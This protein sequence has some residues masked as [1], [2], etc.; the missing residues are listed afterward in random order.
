M[1]SDGVLPLDTLIYRESDT[2]GVANSIDSIIVFLNPDTTNL[3]FN[4]SANINIGGVNSNKVGGLII[5]ETSVRIEVVNSFINNDEIM[6]SGL[7]LLASNSIPKTNLFLDATGGIGVTDFVTIHSLRVGNPSIRSSNDQVFIAGH[8]NAEFLDN[9]TISEDGE[10][11]S[12]TIRDG[13]KV[14]LPED[15]EI[16]WNDNTLSFIEF[17]NNVT[18]DKININGI[19]IISEKLLY[20]PVL[21]NFDQN[22]E[23]IINSGLMVDVN[24]TNI[25]EEDNHRLM[26]EVN[27]QN[28]G[29]EYI[30]DFPIVITRPNIMF[31][32]ITGMIVNQAFEIS[33]IHIKEHSDYNTIKGET[34]INII[35]PDSLQNRVEFDGNS[36]L[37]FTPNDLLSP[38]Y[39]I[40][41]NTITLTPEMNFDPNTVLLI[42]GIKLIAKED[43]I[44]NGNLEFT[45]RDGMVGLPFDPSEIL[46]DDGGFYISKPELSS[47]IIQR[48]YIQN[49]ISQSKPI[50]IKDDANN[51]AF[52][53]LID[54][55]R[56]K[57]PEDA[58]WNVNDDLISVNGVS[59]IINSIVSFSSDSQTV[60]IKIQNSFDDEYLNLPITIS[61]LSIIPTSV[62]ETIGNLEFKLINNEVTNIVDSKDYFVGDIYFSSEKQNV[63]MKGGDEVSTLERITIKE[64]SPVVGDNPNLR[65]NKLSIN[66]PHNL[67][68]I[69]NDELQ[70]LNINSEQ[71]ENTIDNVINQGDVLGRD[72]NDF[73]K[74][75]INLIN[76]DYGSTLIIDS[77]LITNNSHSQMQSKSNKLKLNLDNEDMLLSDN[78]MIFLA[79]INVESNSDNLLI[80]NE[81]TDHSIKLN[82]IEISNDSLM[83]SISNGELMILER[84]DFFTINIPNYNLG[85]EISENPPI[86]YGSDGQI[87]EDILFDGLINDGKTL[88][89]KIDNDIEDNLYTI[90]NLF[91]NVDNNSKGKYNIHFSENNKK[92]GIDKKE[93][94][95]DDPKIS[96]SGNKTIY[97]NSLLTH[98]L[99]DITITES[100]YGLLNRAIN[101]NLLK[102]KLGGENEN[103]HLI[104]FHKESQFDLEDNG[105]NL[106]LSNLNFS[107][108]ES[109]ELSD[110]L[111]ELIDSVIFDNNLNLSSLINQSVKLIIDDDSTQTNFV[112]TAEEITLIPSNFFTYP[113]VFQD[114]QNQNHINY[115]IKESLV[116]GGIYT[117]YPSTLEFDISVNSDKIDNI[118]LDVNY[119]EISDTTYLEGL[120]VYSQYN[121]F[122]SLYF[123]DLIKIDLIIPDSIV[124]NI[125]SLLDANRDSSNINMLFTLIE[126]RNING[127][128]SK[129][130]FYPFTTPVNFDFIDIYR[131]INPD[132]TSILIASNA[133]VDPNKIFLNMTDLSTNNIENIDDGNISVINDT[134]EIDLQNMFNDKI[135]GL[136]YIDIFSEGVNTNLIN[137]IQFGR[138]YYIDRSAPMI[139]TIIPEPGMKPTGEGLDI[140]FFD[141]IEINFTEGPL[142]FNENVFDVSTGDLLYSDELIS[143]I[144][145]NNCS[146]DNL[147]FINNE[148][149]YEETD[150]EI[151]ID[152][153]NFQRSTFL[154]DFQNNSSIEN[155]ELIFIVEIVDGAGNNQIDTLRYVLIDESSNS[156]LMNYPNPFSSKSSETTQFRY[157][158]PSESN[159]GSLIIYNV[160]GHVVYIKKLNSNELSAGTHTINWGGNTNYGKPLASGVYFSIIKFSNYVTRVNKV[161]II[162]E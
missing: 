29:A 95:I 87:T 98:I 97:V 6:I 124:S 64:Q 71:F 102:L 133:E 117:N 3:T 77:L 53:N 82:S 27:H 145:T 19:E 141:E 126:N 136:Y 41:L 112:E 114:N 4:T 146:V 92:T 67:S 142:F 103:S 10:V 62:S 111:I 43:K 39:N 93:I 130:T 9:V 73:K 48:H 12:I 107:V 108:G 33:T 11:G 85:W 75:I 148:F 156:F 96:M 162:N 66:I 116:G 15:I 139:N 45:I 100:D 147:L 13:I 101:N 119:E 89:F 151:L 46:G 59:G 55:I 1:L 83:Y 144:F 2:T 135:D 51:P 18:K 109:I 160:A 110:I 8:Q 23:L 80:I 134:I 94:I 61:G 122:D 153:N 25:V 84:D 65:L 60:M 40:S 91:L 132:S 158:L 24:E 52:G 70:D 56:I 69:W 20:I 32:E 161:A 99:P 113:V 140:T 78:E 154:T 68:L 106:I 149:V 125:N 37:S 118:L 30:D 127:D 72:P 16:I 157:S 5:N 159:N 57:I 14:H 81:E 105:K 128:N 17:E 63:V 131:Q 7:E 22:D 28:S 79:S 76:F 50:I 137:S 155:G 121:D 129:I 38:N 36:E 35:I 152:S 47:E 123:T 49:S 88:S 54:T 138:L 34:D 31:E 150:L 74:F 115:Y 42:D 58:L 120:D 26:L 104:K 44:M 90:N 143:D 86:L 21:V